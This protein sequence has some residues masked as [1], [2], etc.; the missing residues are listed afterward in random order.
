MSPNFRYSF[1]TPSVIGAAKNVALVREGNIIEFFVGDGIAETDYA[2]GD[3]VLTVQA[4]VDKRGCRHPV[5]LPRGGGREAVLARALA[6]HA[7]REAAMNGNLAA[8]DWIG[9]PEATWAMVFPPY[10]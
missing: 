6:A 10:W 4:K 1:D 7:G 5:I 8:S 9:E 3:R 2:V